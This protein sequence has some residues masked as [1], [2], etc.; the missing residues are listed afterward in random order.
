[1]DEVAVGSSRTAADERLHRR[2][3]LLLWQHSVQLLSP[4]GDS[5]SGG[6][7]T[8]QRFGACQTAQP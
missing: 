2:R 6:L 1:M 4:S 5:L 7:A 8:V 3:V